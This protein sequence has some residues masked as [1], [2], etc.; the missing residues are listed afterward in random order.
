MMRSAD[1]PCWLTDH[2]S[3]ESV[4]NIS[5]LGYLPV[6]GVAAAD[7]MY[8]VVE[9]LTSV[10]VVTGELEIS[11]AATKQISLNVFTA[12]LTSAG[13]LHVCLAHKV[14]SVTAAMNSGPK[15]FSEQTQPTELQPFKESTFSTQGLA[16]SGSSW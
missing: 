9:L 10:E 2:F 12:M 8:M 4:Y 1:S 6:V 11:P 7:V 13:D 3:L 14:M 16:Q 5:G 15:V